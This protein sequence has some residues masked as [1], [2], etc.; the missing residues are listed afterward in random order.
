MFQIFAETFLRKE[1]KKG[2][3]DHSQNTSSTHSSETLEQIWRDTAGFTHFSSNI[4]NG[5]L[6]DMLRSR[7]AAEEETVRLKAKTSAMYIASLSFDGSSFQK[8][9]DSMAVEISHFITRGMNK[10]NSAGLWQPRARPRVSAKIQW[11]KFSSS[12]SGAKPQLFVHNFGPNTECGFANYQTRH[13]VNH[14]PA[15][16]TQMFLILEHGWSSVTSCSG[17]IHQTPNQTWQNTHTIRGIKQIITIHDGELHV[18][19]KGS[20]SQEHWTQYTPTCLVFSVT[21]NAFQQLF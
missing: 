14:Q 11:L 4:L 9:S 16:V 21:S 8:R 18:F 7:V 3:L 20:F 19:I 2:N 17:H 15:R 5:I 10:K 12:F 6:L 13:R 1:W